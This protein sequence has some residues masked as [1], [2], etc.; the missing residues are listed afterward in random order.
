MAKK[1]K[2]EKNVVATASLR[3]VRVSPQK[4]R[5]VV[6]MIKNLQVE[7]ALNAL[8]FD[9]GKRSTLIEKLIM[10]AIANAREQ[11]AANVDDLWVVGA[12]VDEGRVM[13][14]YKPRA[15]GSA[16]PIKRRSSH[17]TVQLGTI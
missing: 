9:N 5:I 3:N 12:W 1:A 2:K 17:V 15:R 10:S 8:R 4:T 7:S 13:T 11:S 16:F 14:R 6:N